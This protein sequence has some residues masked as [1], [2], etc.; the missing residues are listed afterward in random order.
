V[1][2]FLDMVLH[3]PAVYR[4]LLFNRV[5]CKSKYRRE[6]AKLTFVLIMFE[7]YVKWMRYQNGNISNHLITTCYLFGASLLELLAFI[8]SV[9]FFAK[10]FYTGKEPIGLE[11]C[12]LA[13]LISSFGKF[14]HLLMVIWNYYDQ[15]EYIWLININIL[16]CNAEALSVL[17]NSSYRIT[18]IVLLLGMGSRALVF[19]LFRYFDPFLR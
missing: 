5:V 14:V 7:V 11:S 9:F 2:L 10:V 8:F 1:L 4:H 17:F 18:W 12:A 16:T 15:M 3:K 19:Q 6:L 13:L